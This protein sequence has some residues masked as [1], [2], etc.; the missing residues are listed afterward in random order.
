M[1]SYFPVVTGSLTVS[2]SVNI[3][4]G[5]TASGGISI[6]GSIASASY[7]A[8]ASFVALAQSASNAVAA[9]T[10][11][12]ANN[13]TVAGTLT[14]QTLV[15]QTITSSVDFVTGS[16]RFGSIAANTH[17]FTGSVSIS[18]SL[19]GTS[20]TFSGDL[21]IDTNTLYVDSTNN[22]VGIGTTIPSSQLSMVVT[23][24]ESILTMGGNGSS[25]RSLRLIKNYDTF[26]STL[27]FSDHPSSPAGYFAINSDRTNECMRIIS[28]GKVGIGT[29]TPDRL[30]HL[31]STTGDAIIRLE[32]NSAAITSG[33]S[34]G[35][36]EW[37]GRD[38]STGAAGVRASI[39]VISNGNLGEANMVFRTS[40]ANFSANNDVLTLASTGAATFL[41]S[42]TA[43]GQVFGTNFLASSTSAIATLHLS[44]NSNSNGTA[45]LR[46]VVRYIPTVSSGTRTTIP[47]VSQSSAWCQSF[48][49]VYGY[50]AGVNWNGNPYHFEAKMATT[51]L[52]SFVGFASWG[53]VGNISSITTSATEI[54]LNHSSA[55]TQT[56]SNGLYIV[57]EYSSNDYNASINI[58]GIVLN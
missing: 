23:S 36:L 40:G 56:S 44:G 33:Q 12:F 43:D 24:G 52:T 39:D 26:S 31:N 57:I 32:R 8:T 37:E 54:Y 10:A 50:S 13:L 9:Q 15:V 46:R 16:T 20:A 48:I 6:S 21:T 55:Y 30:L 17:V 22:R 47:I 53:V 2:G 45:G 29:N 18:G 28:D 25:A 34:Y 19:S 49:K 3:S 41:S 4:G 58:G 14:A 7:A 11:S 51:H 5:I 27:Y 1:I 42:V 35:Q 38:G